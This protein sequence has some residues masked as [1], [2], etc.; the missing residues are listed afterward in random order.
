MPPVLGPGVAVADPLEVLRR[1]Q[2]TAPGAVA[3]GEQR[4]LGAGHALLDHDRAPGVAERLAGELG[5]HVGVG[6]VERPVTSTPLP[7]ASP[8]VLITHGPGSVRRKPTRGL[9]LGEAG[10]AGGG[11]AGGRHQ[12]LHPRLRALEPAPSAP[13]RRRAARRRAARRPGRPPAAPRADD[14]QVGVDLLGRGRPPS[15]GSRV[16]RRHDHLG[17]AGQ[18]VGQRML[19]ASRP[20]DADPHRRPR[21]RACAARTGRGPAHA[22]QRMGT[23]DL[24]LEER[25]VVGGG[26]GQVAGLGADDRSVDQPG[27]LLVDRAWPC[28]AATGRRGSGRGGGRRPR[29]RRTPSR[30]RRRRARRAW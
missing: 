16:A 11:D 15:R 8:S 3:H 2:G 7:A 25:D 29:R 12:L 30:C 18:H 13:G 28:G 27:Q 21:L 14:E 4:Q 20:D 10:V 6:L 9:D 17:G 23:P 26:G 5:P 1:G 24:V 22:D 19:A